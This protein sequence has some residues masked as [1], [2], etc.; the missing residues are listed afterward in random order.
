MRLR[1]PLLLLLLA[2]AVLV[3]TWQ[4]APQD[5]PDASAAPGAAVPAGL[6][7]EAIAT[8]ELIE[9][10]GPFPHRQDGTVFQNRE[11]LLPQRPRGYYR[12]YTVRT[13]G[14]S[15]RGARRIVTGGN[16]PEVYYYT[17][18]HYRSF[19]RLETGP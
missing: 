8:L 7:P 13:P 3:S 19:R 4:P 17:E 6:P 12:E 9:R 16:P 2:V 11:G 10:G 1:L 14:L 5:A 18:D 15:H